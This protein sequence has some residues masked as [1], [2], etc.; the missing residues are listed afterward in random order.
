MRGADELDNR[1]S[2]IPGEDSA[3]AHGQLL[4]KQPIEPAPDAYPH[5]PPARVSGD[6]NHPDYH[7]SCARI[8]VLVDGAAMPGVHWY[9]AQ[10]GRFR[11]V[12][13]GRK[14]P[15]H[16]GQV[17]VFWKWQESRQERRA[18]ERWDAKHP[19]PLPPRPNPIVHPGANPDPD[20]PAGVGALSAAAVIASVAR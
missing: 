3:V 7:P 20:R 16:E 1:R 8:G 17:T 19:Q 5:V 15:V 12:S 9:D 13:E 4:T 6:P 2:P 18:R 10:A 11:I 14:G